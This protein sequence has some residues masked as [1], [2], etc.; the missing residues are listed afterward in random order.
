M[1]LSIRVKPG[2]GRTAVGG[3]HDGADEATLARLL[4]NHP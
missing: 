1:R 4:A 2:S 3:V